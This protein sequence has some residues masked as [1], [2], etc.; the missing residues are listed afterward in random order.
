MLGFSHG[1]RLLDIIETV[2][3][4]FFMLVL[5]QGHAFQSYLF[6]WLSLSLRDG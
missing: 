2:L 4:D 1:G 5:Y 3:A 6:S